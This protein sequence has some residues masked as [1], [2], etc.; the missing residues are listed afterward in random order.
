LRLT[1]QGT[2]LD[3]TYALHAILRRALGFPVA[4]LRL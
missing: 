4:D 1:N 3:K 2:I